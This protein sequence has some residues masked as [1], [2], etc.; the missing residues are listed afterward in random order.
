MINIYPSH[1]Y[2]C[3]YNHI[4]FVISTFGPSLQFNKLLFSRSP[5]Y[6]ITKSE[7]LKYK[8]ELTNWM[9]QPTPVNLVL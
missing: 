5:I 1:G 9:W 2:I 8:I 3:E 7:R 4:Y 6:A